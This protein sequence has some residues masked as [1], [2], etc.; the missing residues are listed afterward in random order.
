MTRDGA[1][2]CNHRKPPRSREG[3]GFEDR[4]LWLLSSS[5]VNTNFLPRMELMARRGLLRIFH[6]PVDPFPTKRKWNSC[7]REFLFEI[8]LWIKI[9]VFE[10]KGKTINLFPI[11]PLMIN[12]TRDGKNLS[13][14]QGGGR[15]KDADSMSN[16]SRGNK[17]RKFE[18]GKKKEKRQ[19]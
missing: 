3:R 8:N 9:P 17:P 13:P 14:F 19:T 18:R 12:N 2:E 15:T 1:K 5:R 6:H 11:N 4:S 7:L 16:L 10:F